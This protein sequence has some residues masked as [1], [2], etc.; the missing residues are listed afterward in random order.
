MRSDFIKLSHADI[1][2][3]IQIMSDLDDL[4]ENEKEVLGKLR[5]IRE[6]QQKRYEEICAS[7]AKQNLK[8]EQQKS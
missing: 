5:K 3:L 7:K 4:E 8:I 2:L 1:F 6:Q